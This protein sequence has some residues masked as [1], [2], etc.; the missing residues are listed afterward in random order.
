MLSLSTFRKI[1]T[2]RVVHPHFDKE[3]QNICAPKIESA[4]STGK[5]AFGQK[6]KEMGRKKKEFRLQGFIRQN[7]RGVYL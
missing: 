5:L 2:A 3:D 4:T 6:G 7:P 1:R